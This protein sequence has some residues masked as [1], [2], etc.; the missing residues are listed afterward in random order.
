MK[1]AYFW[2][3]LYYWDGQFIL[4]E[5]MNY[6][7]TCRE[8][9]LGH[10]YFFMTIGNYLGWKTLKIW[11]EMKVLKYNDKSY[12]ST[13]SKKAFKKMLQKDCIIISE[14]DCSFLLSQA[15]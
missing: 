8:N 9:I 14:L 4:E 2:T 12:S 7:V 10:T 6:R 13:S 11:I 1:I 5:K 3:N 15:L